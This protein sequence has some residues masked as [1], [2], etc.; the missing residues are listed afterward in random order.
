[1]LGAW[2]VSNERYWLVLD[3]AAAA[4]EIHVTKKIWSLGH[5]CSSNR[6][7]CPLQ[8]QTHAYNRCRGCGVGAMLVVVACLE[9]RESRR[10]PGK[11]QS[12]STRRPGEYASAGQTLAA[13][14]TSP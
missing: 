7:N 3:N 9:V 4:G 8:A 1:M 5:R 2:G 13:A 12:E 11:R 6:W 14:V 10:R